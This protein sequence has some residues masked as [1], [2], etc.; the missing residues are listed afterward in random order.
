MIIL[1]GIKEKIKGS[2]VLSEIIF[3]GQ[4]IGIIGGGL[5]SYQLVL[6]AQKLGYNTIVLSEDSLCRAGSVASRHIVSSYYDPIFLTELASLSDV[7]TIVTED[8]DIEVIDYLKKIVNVPQHE[9]A[10][11]VTQDRLLRKQFLDTHSINTLPF[12]TA[13]L[14]SDIRL[15]VEKVGFPLVVKPTRRYKSY[16]DETIIVMDEVDIDKAV[17][18]IQRGLCMVEPYIEIKSEWQTT[19]AINSDGEYSMFPIIELVQEKFSEFYYAKSM[20]VPTDLANETIS[21]MYLITQ[22]VASELGACGIVNVRFFLTEDDMLYV[23]SITTRPTDYGLITMGRHNFSVYD[24][25]IRSICNYSLPYIDQYESSILV[26][27]LEENSHKIS[28]FMKQYKQWTA[29]LYSDML[30]DPKI[31]YMALAANNLDES[32]QELDYSGLLP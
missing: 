25:H 31:G 21:Q 16:D 8:I 24:L 3:P 18:F 30:K 14:I 10:T 19:I 26:P 6:S 22:V 27:L 12:E 7:I 15:A 13:V 29:Y 5:S 2:E 17:P 20:I 1:R 4:T 9:Y 28:H 23:N 32:L 11:S